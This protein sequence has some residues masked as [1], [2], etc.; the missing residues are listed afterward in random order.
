[1]SDDHGE[2]RQVTLRPMLH[3][4]LGA[5]HAV[6]RGCEV[7]DRVPIVTT[8]TLFEEELCND[9]VDLANDVAVAEHKG[10]IVGYVY[11]YHLPSDVREER[12]YV[13]GN[14]AP[15]FRQ[16]GVGTE[17]MRWA[18]GRAEQQLRSS[19]RSLP[20]FIR[21]DRLDHVVGAHALY[22]SMGMT[23]VRYHEELLR[24]LDDLPPVTVPVGA[25]IVP[26][27]VDRTDELRAV[28][29]EAFADHWGSTPTSDEH[30]RQLTEGSFSRP[31]LSSAVL[32]E[33]DRIVALCLVTRF[34]EDDE[35]LGRRDAWIDK[36]ATVR[37][38]RGRG[39]ASALVAHSLQMFRADGL[40]HA[41]IGVDADN[42]T[43]AARLYK[44]LGFC[45]Q[46]R[47]TT[48]QL[49]V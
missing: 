20:R 37:E 9:P 25:R 48:S 33:H 2:R 21:V 32:D 15:P 31:D 29:N 13:F 36:L 43:G 16:Q 8:L 35:L 28:K 11:T 45:T 23:P 14:V 41:S 6:L 39:L 49:E 24:S 17:L 46:H 44:A 19:G 38:W 42:P 40:T 30:W 12:C 10:S 3:S 22:R 4:D 27:P 1:M 7:H 34:P 47:S 18:M 5:M 26:W